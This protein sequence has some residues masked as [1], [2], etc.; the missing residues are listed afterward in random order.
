MNSLMRDSSS[1]IAAVGHAYTVTGAFVQDPA[2]TDYIFRAP[3]TNRTDLR[4]TVWPHFSFVNLIVSD[5]VGVF[6]SLTWANFWISSGIFAHSFYCDGYVPDKV[7]G[8]GYSLPANRWDVDKLL[9]LPGSGTG[10]NSKFLSE[11][12]VRLITSRFQDLDKDEKRD[13][14]RVIIK[15]K[16]SFDLWDYCQDN[17]LEPDTHEL[18]ELGKKAIQGKVTFI[19]IELDADQKEKLDTLKAEHALK[20]AEAAKNKK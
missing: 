8:R 11:D 12:D 9:S 20:L 16:E 2:P 7:P 15:V 10:R 14:N 13:R 1:G 6:K 3:L 17:I 5:A 4:K 18:S 19:P